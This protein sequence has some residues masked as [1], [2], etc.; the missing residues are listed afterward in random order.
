MKFNFKKFGYVDKGSLELA[1]LTLICGPNNVGKTYVNYAIY[2]FIRHFKRLID[3]SFTSEQINTLKNE[4]SLTIDLEQYKKGLPDLIKSASK[5]Y[6]QTLSDYFN[7]PDD[8]FKKAQIEFRYDDFLIDLSQEFKKTTKF[9]RSETLLFDKAPNETLF[10]IA[11][12]VTEKSKLPNRILE[13]VVRNAISECLFAGTLPKPFVVTSERTGIAL[14]YKELDI[15]KNAILHHLSETDKP[16]PI[17]LLNSMRSRY[18][19]PIQDNIDIIRDYDTLCKRKSFIREDRITYKVV[20]DA[21]YDLLGGSFKAV[22]KQV[23]YHPRKERN[24]DKVAVPVYIA[25]SSIKSLFLIDLYINCLAEKQ[26]LLII[27][28]PELNLHPDNQR[29]MAGLIAR[30]VNSGIKVMLTTH[31]DYLIRELNNRIMLNNEIENKPKIMK[32]EKMVNQDI[33][34]PDQVKAFS[35]KDN[36][37]IKQV[38]VDN[39]GINTEIF[40]ELIADANATSDLI[41]YSIKD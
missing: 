23:L 8:F 16:D 2:G 10:S 25:S 12:Q 20:L 34:S 22:D 19:H 18:A 24:R 38:T 27:D 26:G 32:K 35:L 30:L 1:D 7:A 3:I 11:L 37:S 29:K 21:L 28:E 9:G 36:H 4:G 33:L 39:Y 41:Y 6:S 13:D 15:S 14:F 40:D 5:K 17:A 31:S